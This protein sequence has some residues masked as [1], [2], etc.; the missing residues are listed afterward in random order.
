[1][2]Y[3]QP[4]EISFHRQADIVIDEED[5]SDVCSAIGSIFAVLVGISVAC[6]GIIVTYV[7]IWRWSHVLVQLE[8]AAF[9]I[10]VQP[11]E[12]QWLEVGRHSPV[13]EEHICPLAVAHELA[14]ACRRRRRRTGTRRCGMAH[15]VQ[16]VSRRRLLRRASMYVFDS[17][18]YLV[19]CFSSVASC[20]VGGHQFRHRAVIVAW[21]VRRWHHWCIFFV[22]KD[23]E[24]E[25]GIS[26]GQW[27][28]GD[29]STRN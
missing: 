22:I 23:L 9:V 2:R 13:N 11:V 25:L 18:R 21:A 4:I 3:Q 20:D 28:H 15:H 27:E 17:A 7:V 12:K 26:H 1:M 8:P 10:A 29:S 5:Q 6:V 16:G 14:L 19:W 24:S